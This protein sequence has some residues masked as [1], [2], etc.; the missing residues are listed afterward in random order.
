MNVARFLYV[1]HTGDEEI[2]VYTRN[3]DNSIKFS[4]VSNF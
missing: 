3:N 4:H 1:G 2:L